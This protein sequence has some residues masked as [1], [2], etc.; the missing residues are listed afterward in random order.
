MSTPQQQQQPP[1]QIPGAPVVDFKADKSSIPINALEF[2]R[3]KLLQLTRSL[4][5][6]YVAVHKPTLP[7]WPSLH[8]QF[9]IVLKQL[10]SLAETIGQYKEILARSVAYPLPSYPVLAQ[11]NTLKALLRKKATPEVENWIAEGQEIAKGERKAGSGDSEGNDDKD[12]GKEVKERGGGT[13]IKVNI[14]QD[15]DFSAFAANAVT[16]EIM[17]H[18]W[19]GFLTKDEID[20]GEKDRGLTFK[21]KGGNSGN[22]DGN[23]QGGSG[24][25]GGI[26][27]GLRDIRAQQPNVQGQPKHLGVPRPEMRV[28]E[29]GGWPV[30]RV[31]AFMAVGVL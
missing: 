9:N 25:M 30:E 28:F 19:G 11:D 5:Q 21:K 10:V 18:S 15:E 29:D 2:L 27:G 1:P 17:Q 3:V 7:S 12:S 31:V 20:R 26:G 16:E 23:Q 6:L 14:N 13:G 22:D 8:S 4:T 24:G